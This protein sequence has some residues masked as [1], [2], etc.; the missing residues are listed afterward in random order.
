MSA[1]FN[2]IPAQR[3]FD[4]FSNRINT[5]S[6]ICILCRVL[7]PRV[8]PHRHVILDYSEAKTLPN[9]TMRRHE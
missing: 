4:S 8:F 2:S 5:L 9:T 7:C 1:K 3:S 6:T